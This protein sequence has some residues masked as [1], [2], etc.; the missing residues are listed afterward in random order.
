[1]KPGELARQLGAPPSPVTAGPDTGGIPAIGA[2]PAPLLPPGDLAA[3]RAQLARAIGAVREEEQRLA[4]LT[5]AQTR[6]QDERCDAE[7]ALAAAETTLRDIRRSEP[8]RLAYAYANSEELRVGC[9]INAAEAEV[10]HARETAEH[11]QQIQT[12]LEA[13]IADSEKRLG[14]LQPSLRQAKGEFLVAT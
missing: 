5:E 7:D 13:E 3:A 2:P 14:F 4:V 8:G 10:Q 9:D 12:A 6:C 1:M 11:V